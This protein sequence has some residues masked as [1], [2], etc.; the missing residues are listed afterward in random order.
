MVGSYP[1]NKFGIYDMHGNVAELVRDYWVDGFY[2]DT[3]DE[4]VEDPVQL[5]KAALRLLRGGSFANFRPFC[6]SAARY[7]LNGRRARPFIGFRVVLQ[8]SK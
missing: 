7:V 4:V 3:A 5:G 8:A 2:A 6:R 1:S